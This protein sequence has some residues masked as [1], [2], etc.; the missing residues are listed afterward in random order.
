MKRALEAVA[1]YLRSN[2][3]NGRK[4][5]LKSSSNDEKSS[6]YDVKRNNCKRRKVRE[7]ITQW[8]LPFSKS[9][10]CNGVDNLGNSKNNSVLDV[11]LRNIN[12]N[13]NVSSSDVQL[14]NTQSQSSLL[15]QMIPNEVIEYCIS[16]LSSSSDRN[17]LQCTCHKFRDYSNHPSILCKMDLAG[18]RFGRKGVI[19]E[20]DSPEDAQNRLIRFAVARN[21]DAINMLAMIR[22]YCYEDV[23]GGIA[24]L[25]IASSRGH[26]RSTYGLG[27]MLRDHEKEESI[28]MLEHAASLGYFPAQQE[29]F[30]ADV[31]KSKHGE[32]EAKEL[33]IYLDAPCLSLLL[34]RHFKK[35]SW[36]VWGDISHC[37][38]PHC[39]R[40]AYKQHVMVMGK[41]TVGCCLETN[42]KNDPLKLDP[43]VCSVLKG[44]N[45]NMCENDNYT[46]KP[47]CNMESFASRK[48][49]PS[50]FVS[51]KKVSRMKMC[52]SC[53]QAKY[54]SKLCQVYDWRSGR[55]KRECALLVAASIAFNHHIREE[56]DGDDLV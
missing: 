15:L 2:N 9:P 14:H 7:D 3:N 21:L 32:L 53:R 30:P 22:A 35:S 40:W 38:N 27:L 54:C 11:S 55:H 48:L 6:L 34:N 39:G 28:Y 47:N 52:S 13:G 8:L 23:L 1:S 42:K 56:E 24:L 20:I 25:R 19:M 29:L 51:C 37:W 17:A 18:D 44:F 26:V 4:K 5:S 43:I 12:T 46:T 31:L 16:F 10:S 36:V 41:T 50:S 33:S 45:E 49:S